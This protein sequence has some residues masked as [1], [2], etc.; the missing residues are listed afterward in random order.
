MLAIYKHNSVV[1]N[2]TVFYPYLRKDSGTDKWAYD[3]HAFMRF[4]PQHK[5]Y[6]DKPWGENGYYSS[7]VTHNIILNIYC[8][9]MRN[10]QMLWNIIIF[11]N[12][13]YIMIL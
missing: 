12:C 7:T 2:A 9:H 13:V 5:N 3:E 10:L 1:F 11:I 4:T 6:Y 8:I